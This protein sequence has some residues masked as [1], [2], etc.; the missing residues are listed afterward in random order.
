VRF[1]PVSVDEE[2]LMAG[3]GLPRFLFRSARS[4][5]CGALLLVACAQGQ[6]DS[7]AQIEVVNAPGSPT[8]RYLLF[9]WMDGER[10]LV[11]N[12]RVP[13]TGFLNGAATP[14]AVVRIASADVGSQRQILVRGMIDDRQ[15]S[16]GTGSVQIVMSSWQT[17][18]VALAPEPGGGSD[19]GVPDSSTSD[20]G[21]DPPDGDLP[22]TDPGTAADLAAAEAPVV[23]PDAGPPDV[24]PDV[25][26]PPDLAR[27][28][29]PE[30]P[31]LGPVTIAPSA[32]SYVE[33]GPSNSGMNNGKATILEVK[34]QGGADNNRVAYLRFPLSAISGTPAVTATLRLFGKSSG[35]NNA[36]SAYAVMDDT[37]IETAITWNNRPAVGA[38]QATT[39]VGTTAQYREWNVT[40]LVKAQQAAG[41]PN[42][43]LALDMD[44]DTQGSPDTH[45]SR[46]AASNPPQL[47]ITR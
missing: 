19:A 17:T 18:T 7:G 12:R 33:Q 11:S 46:E 27:D 8:P 40:A 22:D 13:E 4:A 37:W 31:P 9:D 15:V 21:T 29:A 38:K 6:P 45:N 20:T 2:A 34:S 28:L 26:T 10:I 16:V 43:N 44:M 35:G 47:V 24:P 30:A 36:E 41:R 39:T 23:P 3:M 42:V 32:D 14:L 25:Q 5:V 1:V